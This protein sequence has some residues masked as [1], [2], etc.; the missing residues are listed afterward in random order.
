MSAGVA[1][2][3]IP[4]PSIMPGAEGDGLPRPGTASRHEPV[5]FDELRP[6]G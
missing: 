6:Y 2:P 4:L 1:L 5:H 3:I